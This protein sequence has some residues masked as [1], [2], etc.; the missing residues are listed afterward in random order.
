MDRFLDNKKVLLH[1]LE[2]RLAKAEGTD[3]ESVDAPKL[4]RKIYTN[5]KEIKEYADYY[6]IS[7]Q[8]VLVR[9]NQWNIGQWQNIFQKMG[10]DVKN[11]YEL[12]ILQDFAQ[13][14]KSDKKLVNKLLNKYNLPKDSTKEIINNFVKE[15]R[16]DDK[17]RGFYENYNIGELFPRDDK[18]RDDK[19]EGGLLGD[20][21]KDGELSDYEKA[22]Q[23]AIDESMR[24]QRKSGGLLNNDMMRMG[25]ANGNMVGPEEREADVMTAEEAFNNLPE[26]LKGDFKIDNEDSKFL[27]NK[28]GDLVNLK[29]FLNNLDDEYQKLKQEKINNKNLNMVNALSDLMPDIYGVNKPVQ[30]KKLSEADVAKLEE[31]ENYF[32]P[33]EQKAEGGEIVSDD[34]M[35]EN[36]VDYIVKETLSEEE[37]QMFNEQLEANPALSDLIDEVV[38]RASEFTGAGPV[39][40]PGTGTSDDI[41]ARLSDGEFVFTAKAVKQIGE[42]ELMK[43]M[44]NAEAAY[45]E[46]NAMQEGGIASI[47]EEDNPFEP[48]EVKVTYDV[49]KSTDV[50]SGV[51]PLQAAQEEEE[52][53][54]RTSNLSLLGSPKVRS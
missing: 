26:A 53:L 6:D 29:S 39:D 19:A 41:P 21:D 42:D 40:G 15:V 46:R 11:N 2:N 37:Q 5:P 16:P 54:K 48:D 25:Y 14:K 43:M 8:A 27:I 50:V 31:L 3:E 34:I 24:E 18:V 20:L 22:R 38:V 45:D 35:E 52:M 44:K 51:N 13:G 17:D 7:E 10:F 30:R 12:N 1:A 4:T 47:E 23:D 36:F 9:H 28:R 49:K 32:N 33:R